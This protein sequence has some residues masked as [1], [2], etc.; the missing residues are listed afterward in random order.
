MR[1]TIQSQLL[2]AFAMLG[3]LVLA[4]GVTGFFGVQGLGSD[5]RYL[6][7]SSEQTGQ[8]NQVKIDL[9]SARL[10]AFNWRNSGS[11]VH[12]EA[13]EGYSNSVARLAS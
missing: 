5:I 3:A 9:A 11:S 8:I 7:T 12:R 4:V 10:S 6:Q 13:F 2:G 1:I